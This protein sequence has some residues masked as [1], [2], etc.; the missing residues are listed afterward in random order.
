MQT[1][2]NPSLRNQTIENYIQRVTELS[3]LGQKIPSGEELDKIASELGIT[4]AEIVS[5]KKLSEDHFIRAQ[6]YCNL[7]HWDD[8]IEELREAVAF[9][10]LNLDMLHLLALAHF[11]RWHDK[12]Q[13]QDEQ[14]IKMRIKQCL[15]IKPDHETSLNLLA[16]LDKAIRQ[17]QYQHLAIASL[18]SIIVG[19][20]AGYFWL[21]NIN[22][23]PFSKKD[24]ELE[25]LR[26]E[27]NQEIE[28]LKQEQ[29]FLL[30]QLAREFKHKEQNDQNKINQLNRKVSQLQAQIL[31]LNRQNQILKDKLNKIEKRPN[32]IYLPNNQVQP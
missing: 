10:P 24:I 27:F 5:A 7:R 4:E 9:N 8:A 19:S 31:N 26:T 3:Q 23:N 28:E 12:H 22:F 20:I 30:N 14:Q 16:N 29:E 11:G 32:R 2:N 21:N 1:E 6:G 25:N 15:E 13:R 17:R 18:F